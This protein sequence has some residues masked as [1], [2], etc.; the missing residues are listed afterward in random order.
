MRVGLLWYDDDPKRDLKEKVARAVERYRQKFGA[1]PNVC[2]VHPS[3]LD[4]YASPLCVD[5]VR[6]QSQRS[7]LRHHFWVGRED[8][9]PPP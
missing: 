1:S 7:V 9:P 8:A 4:G 6:V 5:G 2:Y 3:L